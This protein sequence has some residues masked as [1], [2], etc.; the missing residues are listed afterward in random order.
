[1][2]SKRQIKESIA[3]YYPEDSWERSIQDASKK[4]LGEW[5]PAYPCQLLAKTIASLKTGTEWLSREDLMSIRANYL[6][7]PVLT[8]NKQIRV[9]V[10]QL[11]FLRDIIENKEINSN[12]HPIAFLTV[13]LAKFLFRNNPV[14]IYINE[15]LLRAA[16]LNVKFWDIGGILIAEDN[17]KISDKMIIDVV[18]HGDPKNSE[19]VESLTNQAIPNMFWNKAAASEIAYEI[20]KIDEQYQNL[21]PGMKI[22]DKMNRSEANI[23]EVEPGSVGIVGVEY[24][25]GRLLTVLKKDFDRQFV[26]N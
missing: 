18:Y 11:L 19:C 21:K 9:F 1:M 17:I 2:R 10:T 20:F 8:E 25:D 22:W 12:L 13:Q 26:I 4:H 3:I 24:T 23:L 15:D 5:L 16:N 6:F 14:H 7:N